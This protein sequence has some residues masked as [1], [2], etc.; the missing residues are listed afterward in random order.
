[1][2]H[3]AITRTPGIDFAQ[4]IT[5][6]EL[7]K[8]EYNL[9]LKQH[10][11]YVQTLRSLGL[12][13][14][15]L[16]PLPGYPDAYFVEDVAIVTPEI[17]VITYPGAPARQGEQVAI[18]PALAA[19]L[20]IASI[21]PPGT[22]DGGDVLLINRQFYVGIS[23]RTNEE[24]AQQFGALVARHGYTWM[25]VK[26]AAGL[27]LKSSVNYVGQ[28]TV[29]ITPEF[30]NHLALASYERIL[31]DPAEA[32]ASNTLWINDHLITPAGF[33]NTRQN[34]TRLGMTIIEL[35]MSEAQKMDGGLTCMSLRF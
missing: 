8:P 11:A 26:V 34:I 14:E 12:E 2:F 19:H 3:R 5:T 6:S 33:P 4:G 13:V 28:N 9:I 31:V 24:G 32:Y 22:I 21:Q 35:D 7:G 18:V 10:A 25:P 20:P 30:Y 16:P 23:D 15:V 17:A 27:H 1:M 29:L